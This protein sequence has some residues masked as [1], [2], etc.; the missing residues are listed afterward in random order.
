MLHALGTMTWDLSYYDEAV[1]H[2]TAS[3][4]KYRKIDMGAGVVAALN[5]LGG[6]FDAANSLSVSAGRDL[7]VVS[8][9]RESASAQGTRTSLSRIAGLYVTDP[10][11]TLTAAAGRDVN[12]SAAQISNAAA[13]GITLIAAGNNLNLATVTE[14]NQQAIVWNGANFRKEASRTDIGGDG[15]T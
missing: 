9:T 5:S 10:N 6:V 12:L 11:G 8:Q 4:A 15:L 14:S 2:L 7:N 1:G 13:G 3:L